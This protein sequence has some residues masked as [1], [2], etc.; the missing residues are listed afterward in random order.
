MVLHI[1]RDACTVTY[2]RCMAH[3][4]PSAAELEVVLR[5]TPPWFRI[6]GRPW[7]FLWGGRWLATIVSNRRDG[8][9]EVGQ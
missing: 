8:G 1:R 3:S 2:R 7:V 9:S 6:P 5:S 4:V